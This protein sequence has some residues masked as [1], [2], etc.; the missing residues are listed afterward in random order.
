M[1]VTKG[2]IELEGGALKQMRLAPLGVIP[3]REWCPLLIVYYTFFALNQETLQLAPEK[4][5]QFAQAPERV[6]YQVRNANPGYGPVYLGNLPRVAP[7]ASYQRVVIFGP[8][9]GQR[10][11]FLWSPSKVSSLH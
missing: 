3:R 4:A 9:C 8:F 11:P 7:Q 2:E 5:M 6:L 1:E 10:P